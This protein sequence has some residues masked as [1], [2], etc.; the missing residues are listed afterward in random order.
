MGIDPIRLRKINQTQGVQKSQGNEQS[1]KSQS[2]SSNSGSLMDRL[3]GMDNKLN[4]GGG[5]SISN[6]STSSTN[7]V[8]GQDDLL[9]K[10]KKA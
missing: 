4:Q 2:S 8:G 7:Q 6:S 1:Q 10:H 9:R 5:V 3:N